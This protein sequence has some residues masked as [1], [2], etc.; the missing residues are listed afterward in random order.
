MNEAGEDWLEI[1]WRELDCE[2]QNGLR[3][4]FNTDRIRDLKKLG[5]VPYVW[6]VGV[7]A[8]MRWNA[9]EMEW[10]DAKTPVQRGGPRSPVLCKE[11]TG[12]SYTYWWCRQEGLLGEKKWQR[13][14]FFPDAPSAKVALAKH[15]TW[16]KEHGRAFH[17]ISWHGEMGKDELV[18]DPKT[19]KQRNRLPTY[20]ALD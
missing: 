8:P 10:V 20:K 7:K 16:D 13:S 18:T 11:W 1:D 2:Q 14:Q 4:Y 5:E 15:G 6:I 3:A 12:E 19:K 17:T 9:S